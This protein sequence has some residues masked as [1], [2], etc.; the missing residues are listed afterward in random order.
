MP[1]SDPLAYFLTWTTYGTWLPGDQRGWF[2]KPGEWHK[3]DEHRQMIA[4]LL[5][6]EDACVLNTELRKIVE[7]TI[8]RHCQVRSWVLHAVNCRSNHVHVVVAAPGYEPEMVM[9]QFKAWCT[10]NLKDHDKAQKHEKEAR[11]KWWTER[12]SRRWIN[13]QKSLDAAVEYVLEQQDGP[14]FEK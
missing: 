14:R 2:D 8:F 5:M 3:A 4:S 13:G 12:G 7:A 10:R 1:Y 6:T 11:T 9:D